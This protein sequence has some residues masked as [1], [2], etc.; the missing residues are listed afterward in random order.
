MDL[1][2]CFRGMWLAQLAEHVTSDVA[3]M[4]LSPTLATELT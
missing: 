4:S 3:V 1:K 2:D